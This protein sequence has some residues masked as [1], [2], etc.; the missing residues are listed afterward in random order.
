MNAFCV[1]GDHCRCSVEE[2]FICDQDANADDGECEP[3]IRCIAA[4]SH[5]ATTQPPTDPISG[6][7]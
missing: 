6:Y 7:E 3:N 1:Y 2:G 5:A 4:D